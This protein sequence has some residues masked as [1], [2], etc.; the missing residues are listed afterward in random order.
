MWY[1]LKD[2]GKL[3]ITWP[4]TSIPPHIGVPTLARDTGTQRGCN[5]YPDFISTNILSQ[6]ESAPMPGPMQP[7]P[8]KKIPLN[9]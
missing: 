6:K 7:I 3:G 9:M 1:H 5:S 8:C 2:Q 4:H